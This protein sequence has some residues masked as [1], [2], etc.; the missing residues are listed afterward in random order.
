MKPKNPNNISSW[1]FQ[2]TDP[3]GEVISIPLTGTFNTRRLLHTAV[4][5]HILIY[6]EATKGGYTKKAREEAD[7]YKVDLSTYMLMVIDHQMCLTNRAIDCWNDGLGD[8]IHEAMGKV[9]GYIKHVP[10]VVRK[11]VETAI[12]KITPS[13]SKTLGGCSSCGGSRVFHPYENPLGR[14]GTV[15]RWTKRG[16]K[17]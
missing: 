12:Q 9:D 10:L 17:K 2:L 16:G 11:H 5:S 8:K 3:N 14:A 6:D 4:M 13:R 1:K 15:N 7:L